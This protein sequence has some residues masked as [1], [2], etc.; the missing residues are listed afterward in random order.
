M[1]ADSVV[2]RA[3]IPPSHYPE[4]FN[5]TIIITGMILIR[6]PALFR[7]KFSQE[8]KILYVITKTEELALVNLILLG[9]FDVG[10][11][12]LI[13]LITTL[14][15]FYGIMAVYFIKA[16]WMIKTDALLPFSIV[17]MQVILISVDV[18]LSILRQMSISHILTDFFYFENGIY[19]K[20]WGCIFVL[21][22]FLQIRMIQ[23]QHHLD[24]S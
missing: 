15:F 23:F 5:I 2:T 6:I 7:A 24:N 19:Q 4:L 14:T 12:Y 18:I 17:K 21:I 11:F 10:T 9:I 8:S 22:N 20:I 1:P 16:L 3:Y 13:H